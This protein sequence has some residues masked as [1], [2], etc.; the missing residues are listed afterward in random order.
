[1]TNHGIRS[2]LRDGYDCKAEHGGCGAQAGSPCLSRAG[3]PTQPHTARWDAYWHAHRDQLGLHLAGSAPRGRPL[4]DA[5]ALARTSHALATLAATLRNAAAELDQIRARWDAP[6]PTRT[7][8]MHPGDRMLCAGGQ[9]ITGWAGGRY[10]GSYRHGD[11]DC[12]HPGP[13]TIER[14]QP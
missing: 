8:E 13:V 3:N 14:H 5:D 7:I 6:E 4:P 10:S 1:M 9:K 12:G 2:K 11:A